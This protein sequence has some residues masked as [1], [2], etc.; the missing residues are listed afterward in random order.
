MPAEEVSHAAINRDIYRAVDV[1][2]AECC[3]RL[4]FVEGV[5][6]AVETDCAERI[7]L[8]PVTNAVGGSRGIAVEHSA[9]HIHE[10]Q[11][12]NKWQGNDSE[13]QE[14]INGATLHE[15]AIFNHCPKP[16]HS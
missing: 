7:T 13:C 9:N 5:I 12:F 8:P 10:K 4:K 1:E 6:A 11:R 15:R 2:M 16:N 3:R 14:R